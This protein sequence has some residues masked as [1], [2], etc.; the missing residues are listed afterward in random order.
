MAPVPR[1]AVL[2]AS[3]PPE[4][5]E[6]GVKNV[7]AGRPALQPVWRPALRRFPFFEPVQTVRNSRGG[8]IFAANPAFVT[9][10]IDYIEEIVVVHFA[11]IRLMT[12]GHA[13]DLK[14]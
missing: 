14:V 9:K 3:T 4:A 7:W 11:R 2:A 6:R 10:P 13:C 1:P 8:N 12:L 5:L